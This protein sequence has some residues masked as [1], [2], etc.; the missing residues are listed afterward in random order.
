MYLV[1]FLYSYITLTSMLSFFYLSIVHTTSCAN[2]NKL[3]VNTFKLF[4]NVYRIF[5]LILNFPNYDKLEWI[6]IKSVSKK[7]KSNTQRNF[8][9]HLPFLIKETVKSLN[10]FELAQL[11]Y[12]F[13]NFVSNYLKILSLEVRDKLMDMR[14]LRF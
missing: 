13:F 4:K 12:L 10:H 6:E 9:R 14:V 2:I 8:T 3:N 1:E 11:L 5:C 7:K